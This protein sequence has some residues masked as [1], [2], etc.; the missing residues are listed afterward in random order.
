MMASYLTFVEPAPG[1]L[2]DWFNEAGI[3]DEC[4]IATQGREPIMSLTKAGLSIVWW[5]LPD[6]G[7]QE[8]GFTLSMPFTEVLQTWTVA[9]AS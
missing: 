6:V 4:L 7:S 3:G 2:Q 5:S 8:K 9:Q 1:E